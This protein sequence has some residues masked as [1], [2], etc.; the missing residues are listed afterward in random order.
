MVTD[1]LDVEVENPPVVLTLVLNN[2]EPI[3]LSAFV[4]AFTS[5]ATEYRKSVRGND[6]LENEATIYVKEVRSG[7]I[8]ADL[9]PVVAPALPIIASHT[10]QVGHAIDFVLKWADRITKLRDG[11]IPSGFTR[12]DLKTFT[13]ATVAIANDRN[14]SARL[15]AATFEDGR[16][17]VRAAFIFTTPEAQS[18]AKT[19]DAEYRRLEAQADRAVERTLMIFTRSDVN[20]APT[21]KRSGERVLISEV[22]DKELPLIYASGLSEQRIK[23]VI[24]EA[25]ENIFKKGFVVDVLVL[26]RGSRPIAYKLTDVHDVI[27]IDDDDGHETS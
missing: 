27:D 12:S 15:E 18:V 9:I 7:S 3:E 8:I 14:A 13:D 19:I 6:D 25:D 20:D 10:E 2:S 1:A 17:Q 16:R 24:R 4:G 23:H 11:V 21:D 5:L 22:T 26:H